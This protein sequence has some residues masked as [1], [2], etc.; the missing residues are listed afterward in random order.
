MNDRPFVQSEVLAFLRERCQMRTVEFEPE[1]GFHFDALLAAPDLLNVIVVENQTAPTLK[2][3][4][5]ICRKI[6][7]FAWS[8]YAQQKHNLVTLILVLSRIPSAR[9]LRRALDA[10]NGTARVF[11]VTHSMTRDQVRAALK[12]LAAPAFTMSQKETVGFDQIQTLL[13]GIRASEI[14]E[15]TR[16]SVSDA[17]LKAKLLG[18]L[19]ELLSEVNHALKKS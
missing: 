6:Q 2:S 17:E 19:E 4:K 15:M 18:R 3:L 14:L 7:S 13:N 16:S 9:D 8:I 11:L 1:M 12:P 5:E 10:L